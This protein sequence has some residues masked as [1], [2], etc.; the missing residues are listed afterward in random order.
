ME[1]IAVD[2]E[3]LA[4]ESLVQ[5]I[6]KASP[7]A[8]VHGFRLGADAI[9]YALEHKC[10]IAFL[11]IEL[12]GES[13]LDIAASL[14]EI[15]PKINIIFTTGYG[16]YAGDAFG[17][18]ASG[19]VMKPVTE[20]KIATELKNLRH[21]YEDSEKKLQ[22]KA[23]GNFEV[24]AGGQPLKFQYTK[25]KE[26]LA[27]LVDRNGAMVSNQELLVTLWEDDDLENDHSSYLKNIRKDLVETLA[28][29]GHE[30]VLV[31]Q[32]GKMGILPGKIACDYFDYLNGENMDAYRGEYMSQYSWSELTHGLLF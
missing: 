11:D 17:I 12:R 20:E 5:S 7:K 14:K 25:A 2:D 13:G 6:E 3:K 15:Y 19:Y 27:Y 10:D 31:R 9:T 24:F 1:I 4:L 8:T 28:A 32:R 29:V 16:E 18:H 26:L 22:V 21:P 30:D 23:F